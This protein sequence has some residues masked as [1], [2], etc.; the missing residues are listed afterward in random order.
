[1][2][3]KTQSQHIRGG[4]TALVVLLMIAGCGRDP[5]REVPGHLRPGNAVRVSQAVTGSGGDGQDDM[6]VGATGNPEWRSP[7]VPIMVAGT[8]DIL[9]FYPSESNDGEAMRDG[10][11][12]YVKV[13]DQSFRQAHHER[14][15]SLFN[16][17]DQPH[18]DRDTMPRSMRLDSGSNQN[19]TQGGRRLPVVPR[20]EG[21]TNVTIVEA[22]EDGSIRPLGRGSIP[23]EA[24]EEQTLRNA[25]DLA[26]EFNRQVEAQRRA[27]EDQQST[28]EGE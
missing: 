19:R 28:L 3:S 20:S 22:D 16:E 10:H 2:A 23:R 18:M 21:Q 6:T 17:L 15:K 27:A 14:E 11:W 26:E 9:Y 7:N 1:M 8:V 4:A 12:V 5:V 25:Y 13:H 24:N